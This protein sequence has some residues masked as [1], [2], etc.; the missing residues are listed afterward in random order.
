LNSGNAEG[1]LVALSWTNRERLFVG[2]NCGFERRAFITAGGGVT[3]GD[4]VSFG[5]DVKV[6][7]VNHRYS[8]PDTPHLLQG[9]DRKP[10]VIEEDVWLG[11]NVFSISAS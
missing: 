1:Y 2:S 9:W 6:W 4:W 5:P 10:V 8:D 3:I 11:A 7:S